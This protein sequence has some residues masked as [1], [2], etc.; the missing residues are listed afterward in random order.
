MILVAP[1]ISLDT[2]SARNVG[3]LNRRQLD[4]AEKEEEQDQVTLYL[5]TGTARHAEITILLETR[6]A[7]NVARRNLLM[8]CQDTGLLHIED[9]TR[10]LSVKMV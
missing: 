5:A 9:T 4:G 7:V 6:S 1:I 10:G 8:C 3:R 2:Q